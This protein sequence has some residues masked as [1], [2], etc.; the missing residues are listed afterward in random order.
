MLSVSGNHWEEIKINKRIIEKVKSVHN[1]SDIISKIIISRNF[2]NEEIHSINKNINIYNPFLRNKD[3]KE[4]HKIIKDVLKKN[5]KI[6]I[7]GDYDV[8]GCVS[9]A[10]LVNYFKLLKKRVDYY[11]PD[12]L[13]D[14][15]G[16]NLGLIKKQ[17]KK[18]TK[19]NNYG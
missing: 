12:R 14:G 15:Y 8:D 13:N 1:F 5:E 3:F 7:I 11:I 2:D 17:I 19:F 6:L 4:G 9:T 18:K 10:L 16:A